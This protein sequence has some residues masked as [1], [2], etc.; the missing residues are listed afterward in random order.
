LSVGIAELTTGD[1]ALVLVSKVT[2]VAATTEPATAELQQFAQQ[3]GQSHYGAVQQALRAKAEIVR[4][5]PSMT[6]EDL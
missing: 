4:K 5:L 2:E 6:S 3:L 1:V